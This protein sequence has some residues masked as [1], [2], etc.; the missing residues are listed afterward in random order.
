MRVAV[1][2]RWPLMLRTGWVVVRR[3]TWVSPS[4]GRHPAGS[5]PGT[6]PR[7]RLSWAFPVPD[8]CPP[9]FPDLTGPGTLRL[10][11]PLHHKEV[12]LGPGRAIGSGRRGKARRGTPWHGMAGGVRLDAARAT[13]P[14]SIP[15]RTSP[16]SSWIAVEGHIF[17]HQS[18]KRAVTI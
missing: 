6:R 4:V 18:R 7:S 5:G 13:Y 17:A 3:I 12:P 9:A 10:S 11:G 2:G 1:R 14:G 16:A 15:S 8:E